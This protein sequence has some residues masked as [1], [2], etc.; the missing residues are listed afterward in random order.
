[1]DRKTLVCA[2]RAIG[3]SKWWGFIVERFTPKKTSFCEVPTN[4][5]YIG[6]NLAHSK[7]ISKPWILKKNLACNLLHNLKKMRKW[8]FIQKQKIYRSKVLTCSILVTS[9]ILAIFFLWLSARFL[10]CFPKEKMLFWIFFKFIFIK[11]RVLSP[12]SKNCV[13]FASTLLGKL[14]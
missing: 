6:S 13:F 8:P 2:S 14:T 10:E 12:K 3:A 5:I 11:F 1:M 7:G 4:Q 9:Y